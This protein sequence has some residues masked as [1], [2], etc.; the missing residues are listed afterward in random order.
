MCL[1]VLLIEKELSLE[2]V[3]G[4]GVGVLWVWI[5]NDEARISNFLVYYFLVD[6]KKARALNPLSK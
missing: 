6:L 1:G 3:P 4:G 5:L 2:I